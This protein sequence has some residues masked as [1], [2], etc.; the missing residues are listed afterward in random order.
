MIETI[1]ALFIM[2]LISIVWN[3][4]NSYLIFEHKLD[5]FLHTRGKNAFGEKKPYESD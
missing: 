2:V 4:F 1:V 3:G 5:R